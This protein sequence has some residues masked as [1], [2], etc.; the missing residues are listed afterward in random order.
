[1]QGIKKIL[2][3][4]KE[5][6]VVLLGEIILSAATVLVYLLLGYFDYTVL[7]GLLLGSAVTVFNMFAL[8]FAVNRQINKFLRL[9]GSREMTDEEAEAFAA[10][11]AASIQLAARGSYILRI[12]T[13]VAALVLALVLSESFDVIATVIPLLA[14]RPIIYAAELIKLKLAKRSFKYDDLFE[15]EAVDVTDVNE[16]ETSRLADGTSCESEVEE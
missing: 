6:F 11:H 16:A 14:Y 12:A 2:T 8:S 1:M 5:T 15:A 9:R 3:N 13:M 7:T 4:Y 10:E